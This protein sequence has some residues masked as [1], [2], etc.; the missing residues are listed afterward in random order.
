VSRIAATA[1]PGQP[2]ESK[3]NC[4]RETINNVTS[5]FVNPSSPFVVNT[6]GGSNTVNILDTS[7]GIAISINGFGSDT[8]NVGNAG[9]V[10]GILGPLIIQNP[11][12]FTINNVDDSAD[13]VARNATLSTF[14]SGGANFGSITGLAPA[15]IGYKYADTHNVS[16]T[17]GLAADTVNVFATGVLVATHLSTSGGQDVVNVGGF[18]NTQGILGNLIIQNPNS[19]DTVNVNDSADT[20]SRFVGISNDG[21]TL[22]AISGLSSAPIEFSYSGASVVNITTGSAGDT[23]NVFQT[24]VA[25]NL[26]TSGGQDIVNV[27]GFGNTQGILSALNIQNSFSFTTL[28][29]ND[30]ADTVARNPVLSTFVSGRDNFGS[31]TGLAPADINYDA[32]QNGTVSITTGSASD[33]VNV[34]G[35]GVITNL[36]S[37]GGQDT[38]NVGNAGSLRD[39]IGV[40]NIQNSFSFTTL[41]VN[42]SA[43]PLPHVAELSTF[44]S[45]GANFGSI[46][47]LAPADIS[48]KYADTSSPVNIT[49]AVGQ[50][51]WLDREPRDGRIVRE[52]DRDS[53]YPRRLPPDGDRRS[54]SGAAASG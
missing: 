36:N 50:V 37:F 5:T 6:P 10:Q 53:A 14:S 43:D 3:G 17:T 11:P 9:S 16:V 8:V 32:F 51:L 13:T 25:T 34:L 45:G 49:T 27:G 23:V 39:I 1:S 41:N 19:A 30:S 35:T 2:P 33:T 18:G 48:F 44:S 42:D 52:V 7:A 54:P 12:S 4:S 21:P 31:I 15:P 20:T 40:L 26:S 47:G 29:V 24:G 38:V 28:N 22:G 46:T